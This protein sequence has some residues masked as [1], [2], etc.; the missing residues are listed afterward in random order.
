MP[1]APPSSVRGEGRLADGEQGEHPGAG[2]LM[3]REVAHVV[4]HDG[5][6]ARQFGQ[7]REAR[8]GLAQ[9]AVDTSRPVDVGGDLRH[10]Q[11]GVGHAGS[12]G[13]VRRPTP[14][15]ECSRS[16]RQRRTRREQWEHEPRGDRGGTGRAG[17]G[18][19]GRIRWEGGRPQAPAGLARSGRGGAGLPR[20]LHTGRQPGGA[21]GRD[22]S[23]TRERARGR[24][25]AGGRPWL[26]GRGAHNSGGGS[27]LGRT[28]HR[29][30]RTRR[31]R[32]RRA[33][34]SRCSRPP[35]R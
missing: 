21:R 12:V 14:V 16:G 7:L 1:R 2:H 31:R 34:D 29:R 17:L 22:E 13:L 33:T 15:V 9:H 3:R 32:A 11:H 25:R 18:H 27:R 24:R 10:D 28:G 19:A 26:L 6:E 35:S 8:G 4:D 20:R 23:A 30:G 5:G